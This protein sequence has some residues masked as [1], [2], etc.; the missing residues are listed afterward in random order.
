ML[1]PTGRLLIASNDSRNYNSYKTYWRRWLL[2][3]ALVKQP[4]KMIGLFQAVFLSI[5]LLTACGSTQSSTETTQ[6]E[7]NQATEQRQN[8]PEKVTIGYHAHLANFIIAIEKGFFEDEFSKDG[9]EVE[10]VKLE[11]AGPLIDAMKSGDVDLSSSV[12]S[13]AVSGIASGADIVILGTVEASEQSNAVIVPAGSPIKKIADLKGKKIG[14]VIGSNM[15]LVLEAAL[16]EAGL[17]PGD[18]Q[19]VPLNPTEGVAA[20]ASGAVDAWAIW[21]PFRDAAELDLGAQTLFVNGPYLTLTDHPVVRRDFH[22]QYP[23]L[24]KRFLEAL[25]I[26]DRWMAENPDEAQRISSEAN[27][28]KPE[29]GELSWGRRKFVFRP[30]SEEDRAVFQKVSDFYVGKGIIKEVLDITPYVDNGPIE[31][32]IAQ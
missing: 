31:E 20:F 14:A 13:F 9:V 22:E 30:I 11:H 18:V 10:F 28:L 6:P 5:F 16:K 32:V 29:V 23:Q 24:T 4:G 7:T 15:H 3:F 27:N 25:L 2:L 21:D 19:I 17:Q 26:T 8:L 12:A 1:V